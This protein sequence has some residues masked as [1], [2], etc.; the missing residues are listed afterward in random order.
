V[1]RYHEWHRRPERALARCLRLPGGPD[2][3]RRV[4]AKYDDLASRPWHQ[5]ERF[6]IAYGLSAHVYPPLFLHVV[7]LPLNATR[8]YQM[9]QLIEKVRVASQGNL[10][11]AWLK[12]FM[13]KRSTKAGEIIFSAGDLAA[14]MYYTVAGRYRLK[15]IDG[16]I[17]P[18]QVIGELGLVAPENRRT[19]TFECVED[20]ELLAIGYAQVKQLYFQNPKFGF[21]FL[22]LI[23]QRLFRDIQRLKAK[24]AAQ[25]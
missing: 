14:D 11:M 23:A 4:L 18:G 12:P 6:N 5:Y 1:D 21:Y 25:A 19:V 7:L 17:A 10:D 24:I 2:D 3:D 16:E 13:H 20:G 8:L 9:L 22:D 15:E